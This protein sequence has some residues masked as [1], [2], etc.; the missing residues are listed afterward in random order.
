ME[1]CP[2][3]TAEKYVNDLFQFVEIASQ[4][5]LLFKELVE[6]LM[7]YSEDVIKSSWKEVVYACQ[8]ANGMVSGQLPKIG[9]IKY[10]LDNKNLSTSNNDYKHYKALEKEDVPQN[11]KQNLTL[12]VKYKKM[13]SAGEISENEYH[14]KI[15]ALWE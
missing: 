7:K 11:I 10:I 4:N 6:L 2:L 13:L 5:N 3:E 15:E 14:T 12:A 9:R 1:K 8:P